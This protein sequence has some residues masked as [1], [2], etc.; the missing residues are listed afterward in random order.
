VVNCSTS[1]GECI[2]YVN[3]ENL[4]KVNIKCS[5]GEVKVYFDNAKISSGKAEINLDVSFGEVVLF[6]PK[7]WN[8]INKT[9]VFFGDIKTL[10]RGASQDFPVVTINGNVNFGDAKI[11]FV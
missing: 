11:I 2:K 1:F 5:F 7:T 9:H 3:T 6:I 4:E 8:V 10:S